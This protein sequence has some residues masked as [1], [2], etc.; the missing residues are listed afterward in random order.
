MDIS[1]QRR[2]GDLTEAVAALKAGIGNLILT[3]EQELIT[4]E[5][6]ASLRVLEGNLI[7]LCRP[8]NVEDYCEIGALL[9]LENKSVEAIVQAL[10]GLSELNRDNGN[11]LLEYGSALTKDSINSFSL[12]LDEP[13]KETILEKEQEYRNIPSR[14]CKQVETINDFPQST[15]FKE[16]EKGINSRGGIILV[17]GT[18]G[19]PGRS[20][21][22]LNLAAEITR[23]AGEC[24]VVDADLSAPSL[25]FMTGAMT[26][27]AG[28]SVACTL[29][30]RKR[31]DINTFDDLVHDLGNGTYLLS[32][33]TAADRWR[34]IRPS[35]FEAVLATAR[36]RY[37]WV[38]VDVAAWE[39]ELENQFIEEQSKS[40]IQLAAFGICDYCVTVGIANPVG[41]VRLVQLLRE[42]SEKKEIVVLNRVSEVGS[43]SVKNEDFAALLSENVNEENLFLLPESTVAAEALMRGISF[44]D[45]SFKDKLTL[46]F[47]DFTRKLL[48][49]SPPVRKNKFLLFARRRRV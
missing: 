4:R 21:V 2:C 3:E 23:L 34:E 13:E 10:A 5:L 36:K 30:S 29:A 1:V 41:I 35:E 48:G 39:I 11:N 27:W 24:L 16:D 20:S 33:L 26:Q 14:R 18:A 25:S 8:E 43:G 32:G 22:A 42:A 46:Q 31:L 37:K 12:S 49:F 38:V 47:E 7:V 17:R 6:L 28:L 44:R 15:K 45:C 9:A 19:A 40:D